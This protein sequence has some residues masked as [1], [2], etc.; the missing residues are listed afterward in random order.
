MKKLTQKEIQNINHYRGLFPKEINIQL[1]F[2]EDNYTIRILEFPNAITQAE[3]LDDLIAMVSDCVATILDIPI[4]YLS[5][6]PRYLPSIGLAQYM[7]AFPRLKN[8]GK[9]ELLIKE[10]CGKK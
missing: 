5:F 4:K 7:N 1:R 3:N 10:A 2:C 8:T 9:G 6:M